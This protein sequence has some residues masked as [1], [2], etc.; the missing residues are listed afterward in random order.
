VYEKYA[1]NFLESGRATEVKTYK[2]L[3]GKLEEFDKFILK[4][5][6]EDLERFIKLLSSISVNSVNK[7]LQFTRE[8][9]KYV[10]EVENTEYKKLEL[11]H[12]LK[13]YIDLDKLMSVTITHNHYKTLIRLLTIDLGGISYNNRDAAIL[14]LAWNSCDNADVKNLMKDDLKF[15]TLGGKEICKI[16]LKNRYV[17]IDDKEEIEILK[18]TL[19][20]YKYFVTGS[21]RKREHFLDLRETKAF[22]RPVQT[23]N[24]N[25]ETVANPSE[26]LSKALSKVET[27][28]GTN[29]NL[30][31]FS[32]ESVKRSKIIDLLRRKDVDINDIKNILGKSNSSDIYWL[33]QI[34]VLMERQLKQKGS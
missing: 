23:N 31:E 15:Y 12:D 17:V 21:E 27:I 2:T 29:L 24:S 8:F 16:R 10:A 1:E 4:W 28:P 22:I 26:L 34:S 25:K 6:D 30:Y 18:R 11:L 33:S 20:E 19:K 3:I 9:H 7:Y 32:I 5:E 13:F 14:V